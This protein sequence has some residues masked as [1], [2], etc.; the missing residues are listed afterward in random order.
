MPFDTGLPLTDNARDELFDLTI[1]GIRSATFTFTLVEVITG[2][3][4]DTITPIKNSVPTL[5]HD[6][7][8]AV[9]RTVTLNLDVDDT[10]KFDEIAH[11]VDIA[12]V[13]EDGRSF[14]LGRYMPVNFS[15]IPT[16]AGDLSSVALADEMFVVSQKISEGFTSSAVPGNDFTDDGT[17]RTNVFSVIN[18]FLDKY[19]LFNPTAYQGSLTS[20]STSAITTATQRGVFRDIEYTNYVTTASWQAGANGT[21]VLNDLAVS[22]DYFTPWMGNDRH[23]HMR[24]IFNPDDVIP[25]F[26][27]DDEQTVLRDSIT[28]SN[29]LLNAPNRVVVVS[30]AGSGDNRTSPIV[31]TFDVPDS[32]PHS[33]AKR[34]FVVPEVISLQIATRV[35]AQAIARSLAV[36][37]RTAE[38][39]ELSTP[40]DP[41]HDGYDVVRWDGVLWLETGW[42]MALVEG[43]QMRHTMQRIYT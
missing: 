19:P 12:M 39:V 15:R 29:D 38:R 42:S 11:R 9:K 17:L 43:G 24:R 35:Q 6:T 32:A 21:T 7:T 10:A 37:Q 4:V 28:R 41:R 16:T 30:N 34:G 5:S 25:Q 14:P 3:V 27:F 1:R 31:G 22:G 40:P 23:F 8:R 36:N 20:G 26:D 33:I 2:M 13:L 18:K